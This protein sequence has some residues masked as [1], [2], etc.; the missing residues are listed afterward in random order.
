MGEFNCGGIGA[1]TWTA[2]PFEITSLL[3]SEHKTAGSVHPNRREFLKLGSRPTAAMADQSVVD[4]A[5]LSFST[6][7]R[8][9]SGR[10]TCLLVV[11]NPRPAPKVTE[12]RQK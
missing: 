3:M 1:K 9:S 6:L 2:K 7:I 5:R 11:K 10:S 8:C 12:S 4:A